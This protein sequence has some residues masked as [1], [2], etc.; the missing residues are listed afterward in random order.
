M[1]NIARI[2]TKLKK[3][4]SRIDQAI[5]ALERL[6]HETQGHNEKRSLRN[7]K[8]A[9]VPV[10]LPQEKSTTE[11]AQSANVIFFDRKRQQAG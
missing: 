10:S 7:S 2:L 9:S 1:R 4:R 11:S 3:E 6:R 8:A 5:S